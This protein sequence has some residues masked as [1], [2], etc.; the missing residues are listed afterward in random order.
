MTAPE[1]ATGPA[2]AAGRFREI[3]KSSSL[4]GAA[5]LFNILIGMVRTKAVALLL[6]PSGVGLL[7][8]F[9]QLITLVGTLTGLGIGNSGVRQVAEAAAGDDELK[10]ARTVITLR[11]VAWL[12]GLVGFLALA[13]F[14]LPLSRVSF[15]TPRY[16]G[17]VAALGL[18]LWAGSLAAAQGSLLTGTRRIADLARISVLGSLAGTALSLP[19]Y[20]FW[21]T[22]GIV[23]SLLLF[24]A[25][26]LAI[27]W[28]YARRVPLPRIELPWRESCGEARRLVLLGASFMGA[29]LAGSAAT[30]LIQVLLSRAFGMAGFGIYQAALSLSG[31]LIGFVLSA[32]GT[33]YYPRLSAAAHDDKRIVEMVN[34]QC[35]VALLLA[36]PALSLLLVA[37]PLVLRLFYSASFSGA[38][39]LL[40]WFILS[41]L[42]RVLS[43]PL[44]Y[45][46]LAKGQGRSYLGSEIA[47]D[48]LQV[49]LVY[50][51][52]RLWGLDGAGVAFV[53]LYLF[54]V[55]LMLWLT[56]RCLGGAWD[57]RTRQ[58]ALVGTVTLG[59]L[60]ANCSF[61]DNEP[62][63]W[64]LSLL[65]TGTVFLV[66][67]RLIS[68]MSD[69]GVRRIL[70][71]FRLLP[72]SA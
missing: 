50:G 56:R 72:R 52:T 48:V 55:S 62:V 37:A 36:L 57:Q 23:P 35:Q 71:K 46:L 58:F 18:T 64:L 21:G 49:G 3:L 43:W 39:Q 9:A 7:G 25:A 41:M 1:A 27:S 59:L 12:T 5:S 54:H 38:T 31:I 69:L 32:L 34:E 33:D 15:G 24:A 60:F 47:V 8:L 30:Y 26:N 67:F 40:R 65:V 16:A 44:G 53:L 29:G 2:P 63:G 51:C 70:E 13:A 14:S 61:N 6:G 17:S 28:Y 11:R 4:I 10:L 42:G 66:C 68:R 22:D 19:C 20:Y 45:V